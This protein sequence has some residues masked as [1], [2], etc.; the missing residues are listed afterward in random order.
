MPRSFEEKLA[1]YAKLAVRLGVNVQPGQELIISADINDAPFARLATAEAYKVGAKNVTV[2]Y[3]DEVNILT[4][5]REGS[6][7]AIEYTAGWF[8]DGMARAMEENACRLVVH[9]GNPALLKQVDPELVRIAS[10][11]QAIATQK[12]AA[13]IGN[14]TINWNIVASVSP[15][16]ARMVFPGESDEVAM[17]KLWDAIFQCSHVDTEDP[18]KSWQDHCD[19][20]AK[21]KDWLNNLNF[22]SLHFKGPGTDLEIGLAENN[23]FIGGWGQARNGVRCAPNIPTEEVFGMPHRLRVNGVVSSTKPLSLRGQIVDKIQVEFKDG[24]A[25]KAKAEQGE[26]TLIG[27]L[28]T[29]ESARRLGEVALVPN[30]AAVSRTGLLFFNTLYDENAACHIAFGRCIGENMT[31]YENLSPEQRLAA[32][33]N[34]SAVHVDWMIGSGEIDIDGVHKDGSRVPLMRSGEW[35]SA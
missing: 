23:R 8:I 20:L 14:F 18:L 25:V 26:S 24:V 21:R 34:E 35:A 29:D 4:R 9:G 32:G 28:D 16:W 6:R 15:E 7:E 13:F 10:K 5:Y 33:A 17:A 31:G 27:L 19:E 12:L 1:L 22:Y 3:S 11:A 2:F 30:S